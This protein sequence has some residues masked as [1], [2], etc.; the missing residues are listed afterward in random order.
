MAKYRHWLKQA[1]V[2]VLHTDVT[3]LHTDVT[4][5][6]LQLQPTC[7]HWFATALCNGV[8]CLYTPLEGGSDLLKVPKLWRT[9]P[10]SERNF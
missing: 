7:P 5:L 10:V 8:T 6:Q 1:N 2:T 4:L 9:R 3:L